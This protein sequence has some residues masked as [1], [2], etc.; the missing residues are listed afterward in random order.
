M[1]V[2]RPMARVPA[3]PPEEGLLVASSDARAGAQVTAGRALGYGEVLL[4]EEPLLLVPQD[5]PQF[6]R[7]APEVF[8]EVAAKLGDATRPAAFAA[9]LRLPEQQ[10]QALLELGLP[11]GSGAFE[12]TSKAVGAFLRDFPMYSSALDWPL[13]ARVVAIISERG[14]RLES[15][16][17]AVYQVSDAM[18]HSCRPNVVLETLPGGVRELRCISYTGIAENEAVTVSY[19]PEEVLLADTALRRAQIQQL[20]QGWTCACERCKLGKDAMGQLSEVEKGLSPKMP[21][22]ELEKRLK[23]LRDID[24]ALPFAMAV[25]ARVRFKVAQAC[26]ALLAQAAQQLYALALDENEVVLGQKGLRSADNIRR[27]LSQLLE[28]LEAPEMA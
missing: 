11:Q 14:T 16:E 27:R 24:E 17:Q 20:R 15:G 9:F 3:T 12:A 7:A 2:V 18:A 22:E 10:R 1:T 8:Q 19:V 4:R 6:L 23:V 28:R 25:K 26:E 13:F 21:Q 5:A